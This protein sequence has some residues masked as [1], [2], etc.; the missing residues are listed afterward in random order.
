LEWLIVGGHQDLPTDGHKKVAM[1]I[2][3]SD[4]HPTAFL[5][6]RLSIAE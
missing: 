3:E 6:V 5:M 2:T 1:G 4:R